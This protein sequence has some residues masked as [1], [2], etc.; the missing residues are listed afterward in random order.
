MRRCLSIIFALAFVLLNILAA[1]SCDESDGKDDD[2]ESR[3][4]DAGNMMYKFDY[5]SPDGSEYFGLE[6]FRYFLQT[7][8]TWDNCFMLNAGNSYMRYVPET[9]GFEKISMT[10]QDAGLIYFLS[11]FIP[12]PD[13]GYWAMASSLGAEYVENP[14]SAAQAIPEYRFIRYDGSGNIVRTKNFDEISDALSLS[15]G[16][17]DAFI[18]DADGYIYYYRRSDGSNTPEIMVFSDDMEY[19]FWLGMPEDYLGNTHTCL[20]RNRDGKV[21]FIYI[22]TELE[23]SHKSVFNCLTIDRE[24]RR[25]VSADDELT[26]TIAGMG[27]AEYGEPL[28]DPE[29]NL[30]CYNEIGMYSIKGGEKELMFEWLEVGLSLDILRDIMI[31]SPGLI[32]V[33]VYESEAE[34]WRFGTISPVPIESVYGEGIGSP[35]VLRL[36]I[37]QENNFYAKT[38]SAYAAGFVR[39]GGCRV[40]IVSYSDTEGGLTANQ[41]LARDIAAGNAPDL[42]LFGG[43]LT[44]E[45]LAKS[46]AFADIYNFIDGDADYSR[47]D[48]LPCVLEPFETSGGQL[49]RLV[50]EFDLYT[51]TANKSLVGAERLT[52]D[53]LEDFGESLGDGRYLFSV[54]FVSGSEASLALLKNLLPCMLGE[55]VDFEKGECEPSALSDLLRLCKGANLCTSYGFADAGMLNAGTLL[56][57][58]A[59]YSNIG[60]FLLDRYCNFPAGE[61]A[62]IGYPTVGESG[63]NHVVYPAISASIIKQ[64]GSQELAWNLIKYFIRMK[65]DGIANTSDPKGINQL[66]NFPCTYNGI[67]QLIGLARSCRFV[68][69]SGGV[70]EDP[71]TKEESFINSINVAALPE[72]ESERYNK[73]TVEGYEIYFDDGDESALYALFEN[74]TRAY[75]SDSATRA[76]ILEEASSYFAGVK[77]LEETLKLI[78][79]RLEIRLNE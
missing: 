63:G 7:H 76:I 32:S 39:R 31:F 79:S 29:G 37:D 64:S 5:L 6:E 13:G 49:Q 44:Y 40:E 48:F 27:N 70:Y 46:G 36:A 58:Q 25:F 55:F 9:G 24:N 61:I 34:M 8:A 18:A 17:D 15:L 30:Y 3:D 71:V 28:L 73:A 19:L 69:R 78:Q 66:N 54:N 72:D 52:L 50:T 33:S 4:A 23:V 59:Y 68:I 43:G 38:M 2:S 53:A 56:F 75:I 20:A 22:T 74:A 51:L 26:K 42:V 14:E 67:E 47:S 16:S 45:T 21:V 57:N 35:P 12:L 60:Y 77:S 65:E 62:Y 41:K 10:T 11:R 1:V